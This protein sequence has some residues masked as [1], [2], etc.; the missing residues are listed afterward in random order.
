MIDNVKRSGF[1]THPAF[2]KSG[3]E[4]DR[5]WIGKYQSTDDGGAKLGS[6][7]GVKPISIGLPTLISRAA[8]RNT[9]GITG[10]MECSIYQYAAIQTLALIEMGGSDSQTLI[11]MGNVSGGGVKNTNDA[12]VAQATW[13]GIVGLW[14]NAWQMVDG[15]KID[16]NKKVQIWDKN[17]N[18]TYVTTPCIAPGAGYMLEMATDAG[19]DYDLSMVFT[20]KTVTTSIN[21]STYPDYH[22]SPVAG[23]GAW[24]GD[25]W[26]SGNQGGLFFLRYYGGESYADGNET[27]RLAKE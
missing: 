19:N 21:D 13:R 1:V 18:K 15:M 26:G 25:S 24:V 10:F 7:P 5:Y 14:G 12:T 17:G 27:G 22:Y 20:P 16:A 8:A 9:G 6:Q 11:G 4:I 2:M 3:A 23:S